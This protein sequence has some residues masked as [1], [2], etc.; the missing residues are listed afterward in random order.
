MQELPGIARRGRL[1]M[2]LL[3]GLVH[4]PRYRTTQISVLALM[5]YPTGSQASLSTH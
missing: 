3:S 4:R 1:A 2:G 5:P